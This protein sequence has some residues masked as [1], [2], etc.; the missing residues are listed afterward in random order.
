[1]TGYKLKIIPNNDVYRYNNFIF[2]YVEAG[3][4]L[5]NKNYEVIIPKNK[6]DNEL[7][8]STIEKFKEIEDKTQYLLEQITEV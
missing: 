4:I 3:A 8:I 6:K 7:F 2:R 1:M 5:L